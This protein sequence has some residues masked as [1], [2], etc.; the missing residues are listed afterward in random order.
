MGGLGASK[1]ATQIQQFPADQHGKKN[2]LPPPAMIPLIES[3][4]QQQ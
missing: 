4:P 2:S 3:R 1:G